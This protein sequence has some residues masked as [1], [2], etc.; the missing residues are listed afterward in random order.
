MSR[1]V[2]YARR[3]L[4]DLDEIFAFIAHDNPN[5]AST[6]IGEIREACRRLGD[7]P[8]MGVDRSDIRIGLRILP[9][10]RRLVVAYQIEPDRIRVLRVFSAGQ[11]YQAIMRD[12]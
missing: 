5:R 4:R 9:L 11:D 6:Y 2:R 10:W 12:G 1:P 3:A 8:L 7:S